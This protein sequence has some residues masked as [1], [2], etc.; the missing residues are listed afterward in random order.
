MERADEDVRDQR[1]H[2]S[3]ADCQ[4]D[5]YRK[6]HWRGPVPAEQ[7]DDRGADDPDYEQADEHREC[8]R[9]PRIRT[10]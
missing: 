2:K 5:H 8:R 3:R 6:V 10:R 1:R 4:S 7:V 9:A